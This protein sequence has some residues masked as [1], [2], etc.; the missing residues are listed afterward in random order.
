MAEISRRYIDK[1]WVVPVRKLFY[2]HHWN[3]VVYCYV[4]TLVRKHVAI[5]FILFDKNKHHYRNFNKS[6]TIFDWLLDKLYRSLWLLPLLR[7]ESNTLT[8]PPT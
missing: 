6:F 5:N 1:Y 3:I 8:A 4:T 7:F 2:F